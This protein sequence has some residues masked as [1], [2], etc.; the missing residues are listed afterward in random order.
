MLVCFFFYYSLLVAETLRRSLNSNLPL[1]AGPTSMEELRTRSVIIT[2]W[3]EKA[4][5]PKQNLCRELSHRRVN[6]ISWGERVSTT[7][8]PYQPARLD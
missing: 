8:A 6:L 7:Y 3:P 2:G 5:A 1:P 4:W